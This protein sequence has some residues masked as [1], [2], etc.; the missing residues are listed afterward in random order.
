MPKWTD[1]QRQAIE[2]R[3]QNILVSAAAGSGKTAVLSARVAD[4]VER[5]GS[6]DRLLIVTFANAAAGEMRS[7]IARDLAARAAAKPTDA[8]LR[9]QSL[10]LYKAKICTIDSYGMDLLRRNFQAAGISP[11]FTVLDETELR[12]IQAEV[13]QRQLE[14]YYRTFPEGFGEFELLFGGDT[15]SNAMESIISSTAY[16][17]ESIPFAEGWMEQQKKNLTRSAVFCAAVC[18]EILPVMEEYFAIFQQIMDAEPFP[19]WTWYKGNFCCCR[20]CAP[21]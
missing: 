8:H 6:L 2:T 16:R 13:L 10:T 5:G 20:I 19:K 21:R 18:Q 14:E 15:D 3:G 4:F 1:A 11:D 12:V 9:R 7:R 17:M